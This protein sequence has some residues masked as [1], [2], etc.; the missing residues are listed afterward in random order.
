MKK[1]IFTNNGHVGFDPE[2]EEVFSLESDREGISR[3]FLMKEPMDIMYRRKD[4][5]YNVSAEK[6]DV[7]VVFYEDTFEYPV[8]I[9]KSK[10]WAKNLKKYNERL[11]KQKE[12]W[13]KKKEAEACDADS[14][15]D[16]LKSC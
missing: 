3:I 1:L 4:K 13:A 6:D 15:C 7:V 9:A 11:Q 14:I 10:E 5:A 12:E 16:N 8:V 2:T